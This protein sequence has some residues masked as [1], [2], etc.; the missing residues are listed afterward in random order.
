MRSVLIWRLLVAALALGLGGLL[1]PGVDEATSV[2]QARRDIWMLPDLPRKPD[3]TGQGL[4]LVSS[5]LFERE[6]QVSQSATAVEDPRWRV[7]GIFGRDPERTV[8]VAF[9][10]PN[11]AAI[12]LH[13]GEQLPSGNRIIKIENNEVYVQV[14]KKTLRLGVEYRD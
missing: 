3:L 13:V 1:A 2:V 11:K 7:A 8:M 9:S 14:G 6:A 4:A 10:S 12:Y 5:A